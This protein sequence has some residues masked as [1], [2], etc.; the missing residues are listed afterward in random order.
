MLPCVLYLVL[1]IGLALGHGL[2]HCIYVCPYNIIYIRLIISSTYTWDV[3][4]L[5]WLP[6]EIHKCSEHG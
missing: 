6:L 1:I 5:I 4:Y 2:C 3:D